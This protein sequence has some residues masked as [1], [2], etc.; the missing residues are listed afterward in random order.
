MAPSLIMA[1]AIV[2]GARIA[3]G[4]ASLIEGGATVKEP[5]IIGNHTEIRQGAYMRGYCLVGDRCVVGHTTEVKT[6]HFSGRC[7]GPDT[8]PT[9]EIQFLEIMPISGPEQSLPISNLFPAMSASLSM[10]GCRIPGMRKLGAILGDHAPDR[11]QF[12]DHS[13]G[14]ILGRN[15][16]LMPN[17]TAPSGYHGDR[18]R[19]PLKRDYPRII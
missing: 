11:L 5:A 6:L 17:A 1:G 8:L 15:G 16:I 9:W 2:S 10:A 13:P 3:I 7:Q 18:C 4:K 12:G 14:T 19:L